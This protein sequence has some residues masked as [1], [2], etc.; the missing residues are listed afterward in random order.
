M[1]LTKSELK[2][3]FPLWNDEKHDIVKVLY[4]EAPLIHYDET[5]YKKYQELTGTMANIECRKAYIYSQNGTYDIYTT[6]IGDVGIS[7]NVNVLY[8]DINVKY[9]GKVVSIT[10][11][12]MY[13]LEALTILRIGQKVKGWCNKDGIGSPTNKRNTEE[14]SDEEIEK[15]LNTDL[16][17]YGE[18]VHK[19]MKEC[20]KLY[21]KDNK[22]YIKEKCFNL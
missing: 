17:D 16:S 13:G 3:K 15:I 2:E 7:E 19:F 5:E 11:N 9:K 21:K 18:S 4:G 8:G 6:L 1:R 14:F 22:N 20:V 12:K 10:L